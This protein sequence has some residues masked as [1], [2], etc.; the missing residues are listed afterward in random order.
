VTAQIFSRSFG[1]GARHALALHCTLGHSGNWRG[2]A[3]H[4][5]DRVHLDAI[6]MP[7]HGHSVGWDGESDLFDVSTAAAAHHLGDNPM[8]VVAHSFSAV[9]A[10]RLAT[11]Q[12]ERMRSLV[13]FEPVFFAIAKAADPEAY[14]AH[15]A[16]LPDFVG[17]WDAGDA[18]LAARLFN[19]YWGDGTKWDDFPAKARGYMTDRIHLIPAQSPGIIDDSAGLLTP[20]VL[21]GVRMPVLLLQGTQSPKIVRTINAALAARLPDA[22]VVD[23]AGAGHMGPITHAAAVAEEI[24]AF[25]EVT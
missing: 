10:L 13:L 18:A 22:R 8:D 23:V 3:D 15:L 4:L 14:A 21:D 25:L 24:G 9:V 6:D 7:G 12:P 1:H 16:E 20:G 2:L 17:A 19:R 5:A 11:E